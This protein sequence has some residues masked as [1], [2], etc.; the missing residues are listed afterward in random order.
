MKPREKMRIAVMTAALAAAVSPVRA[1]NDAG[2]T[3][4][5]H[6]LTSL[7][8]TATTLSAYRGQVV[9]VNFW[10]SWCAPCRG[11]LATMNRWNDAW[12]GRGARVV[13][14]SIDKD[15]ARAR[16]FAEE[17][18]LSMTVLH[19]GPSGLARSLDLPALPCTYLLDAQGR[20]VSLVR[21][22]SERDLAALRDKVEALLASTRRAVPQEAGMGSSA[23]TPAAAGH[24]G[25]TR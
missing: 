24:D 3:L 15:A 14:I 6:P 5:S 9:V 22:S 12:A 7:D 23:T 16:R 2:A 20:V 10:A 8:G 4:A 21:G 18:R 11:E 19:D 13:A 25:G 17:V 1:G